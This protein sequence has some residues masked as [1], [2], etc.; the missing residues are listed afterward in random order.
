MTP[1][2]IPRI[3]EGVIGWSGL[4]VTGA[5]AATVGLDVALATGVAEAEDKFVGE[6]SGLESDSTPT[7][8]PT[9]MA[10]AF[11]QLFV[12][13]SNMLRGS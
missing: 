1:S 8:L 2:A 12:W 5:A 6:V 7:S 9:N 10:V 4:S 11:S 3:V 13:T